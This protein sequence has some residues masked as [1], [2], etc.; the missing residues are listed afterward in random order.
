[1]INQKKIMFIM[2]PGFGV[3]KKGWN[4]HYEEGIK[5]KTNFIMRYYNS[6]WN[7]YL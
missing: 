3:S 7:N 2:F 1:M 6:E 5:I 4:T